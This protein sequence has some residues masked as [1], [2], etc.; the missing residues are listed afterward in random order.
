MFLLVALFNPN[1]QDARTANAVFMVY[2]AFMG[3]LLLLPPVARF[4]TLQV[5]RR[6]RKAI[7]TEP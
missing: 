7:D 1:G 6:R 3:V 4:Q 5:Q 2:L